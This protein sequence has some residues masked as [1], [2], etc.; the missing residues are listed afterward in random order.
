MHN[1]AAFI[2]FSYGPENCAGRTLAMAELRVIT[3]LMMRYFDIKLADGYDP[4][5]WQR[6]L[7]DWYVMSVGRV[8]VR[9]SVRTPVTSF[10]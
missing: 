10:D 6:D 2:P 9:L 3:V 8:P 4:A 7:E 5:D 1:T